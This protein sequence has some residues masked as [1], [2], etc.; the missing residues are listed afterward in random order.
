VLVTSLDFGTAQKILKEIESERD[1]LIVGT[2]W[3]LLRDEEGANKI[4]AGE[5]SVADAKERWTM[6]SAEF[7]GTTSLT[8]K[9]TQNEGILFDKCTY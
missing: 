1:D 3:E 9:Q 8:D 4:D 2:M 7:L 6:F 5:F